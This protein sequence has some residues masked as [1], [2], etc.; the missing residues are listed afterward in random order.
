MSFLTPLDSDTWG[1][2]AWCGPSAL[3][4]L[5][6]Q[7]LGSA[8]SR[9][10]FMQDKAVRDIKGVFI[11]EMLMALSDQGKMAEPI[12]LMG[13]Y[14]DHKYGPSIKRFMKER[15]LGDERMYPLLISTH[16]HLLCGQMDW[17]GDNWTKRP[18]PMAKF[19]KLNRNVDQAWIIKLR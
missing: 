13:R 10:A 7:T 6:G 5:T 8:H 4:M 16:N 18:V 11:P 15:P 9:F 12:N 3:A 19:P 14:P 1:R 17:L 2:T